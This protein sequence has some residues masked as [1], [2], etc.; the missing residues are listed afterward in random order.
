[1]YAQ[2]CHQTD[3]QDTLVVQS[4][5]ALA[6]PIVEVRRSKLPFAKFKAQARC[7]I[8]QLPAPYRTHRCLIKNVI[9][10]NHLLLLLTRIRTT[11]VD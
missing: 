2:A 3:V 7:C 4:M 9:Q 5:A 1:M 11:V 10:Y 8:T 6:A